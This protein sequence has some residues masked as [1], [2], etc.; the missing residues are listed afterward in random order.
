MS[1]DIR[2]PAVY[3]VSP[4]R[5]RILIFI[6]TI[7][8]LVIP[9]FLAYHMRNDVAL[10]RSDFGAFYG[11]GR[12]V[13][14]GQGAELYDPAT[15]SRMQEVPTNENIRHG[16][17]FIHA[18]FEALFFVPLSKLDFVPAAWCWWCFSLFCAYATL[19]LLRPYLSWI[20]TRFELAILTVSLFIPLV[21][22]LF[23][24]QDSILTLLLFAFCFTSLQ[25][26]RFW[27]A[28]GAM[29]VAM[30]KPPLAL[31]MIVLLVITSSRRFSILM[32]FI[33]T[34]AILFCSSVA[35]EGWTCVVTYPL[36]LARFPNVQWGSYRV[37]DMPNV[38][39]LVTLFLQQHAS[40]RTIVLAI[41]TISVLMMALT[42]R[43]VQKAGIKN[44]S[45]P[46]VFAL[47]VTVSVLVGFQEYDYDLSVLYLPILLVWNWSQTQ[48]D[49]TPHRKRLTY[50]TT[51]LLLASVLSLLNP[52]VY[53]CLI[54]VFFGLL[55]AKLLSSTMTPR[56]QS[57]Q[58]HESV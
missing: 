34:G 14:S 21:A 2:E 13:A 18:P 16:H 22:T 38:R 58:V 46:L 24:G 12:T 7:I 50:A 43:S 31:P 40:Q 6:S 55:S 20:S 51:V 3:Q 42:V 48:E 23:Q 49:R 28:G 27:L 4:S 57:Q 5:Q 25:R 30:Y 41:I 47:F 19:Y 53:V 35:A 56:L 36:R 8:S 17:Y 1:T 37:S 52:P 45:S 29:A 33:G 9:V 26:G 10:G 44:E 39:G 15:Q 54:V 11:A 32:G